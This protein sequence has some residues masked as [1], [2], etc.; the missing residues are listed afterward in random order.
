MI[1]NGPTT[2]TKC[3]HKFHSECLK[4]WVRNNPSCPA[5]REPVEREEDEEED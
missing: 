3:G 4:R 5:C 2:K 1:N